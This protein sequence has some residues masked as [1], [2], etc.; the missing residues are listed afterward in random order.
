MSSPDPL[1]SEATRNALEAE[2][3]LDTYTTVAEWIRFADT[4]AAITLTVDGVLLGTLIPTLKSYLSDTATVHPWPW[5]H[6]L[7]IGLF[8]GWLLGVTSSAAFAF[9]CI[10]PFR[11][12]GRMMALSHTTHFHP[13]AVSQ[14]FPLS[15]LEQFVAECEQI[16]MVGLKREVLTAILIDAHVS[17]AKYRSVIRSIW[18]LAAGTV[19]AVLF[20]LATLF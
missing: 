20:L 12:T 16:G 8:V 4:K 9:H 14:K 19:F 7:V 18:C 15:R 11:G 3:V 2:T 6:L 10:L 1:P 17:N 13:A 5:W